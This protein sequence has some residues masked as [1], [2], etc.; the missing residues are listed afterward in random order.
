MLSHALRLQQA[1]TQLKISQWHYTG[2]IGLKEAGDL[3]VIDHWCYLGTVQSETE[4]QAL[5]DNAR[6]VFD[7]DTY[8]ILTKALR[9]THEV[10][11]IRAAG[12]RLA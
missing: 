2:A 10:I 6:P 7:K 8:M 3:H 4:V 9:T 1:L 11:H 12:E 5:L